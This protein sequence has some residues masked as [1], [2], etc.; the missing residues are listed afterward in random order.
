MFMFI[1]IFMLID[2]PYIA[3]IFPV[4]VVRFAG[5]WCNSPLGQVNG[6]SH[7]TIPLCAGDKLTE[8]KN[9]D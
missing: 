2:V 6:M 7:A 1:D 4:P 9:V 3:I 8:E 5:W